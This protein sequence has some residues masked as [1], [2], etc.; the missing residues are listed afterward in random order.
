MTISQNPVNVFLS[1]AHK[2]EPLLRQL[3]KHLG[4]LKQ[5]GLISTWDP[6]QIVPGSNWAKMIAPM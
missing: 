6:R 2:D 5:Q 1:Y 3:E 4:L